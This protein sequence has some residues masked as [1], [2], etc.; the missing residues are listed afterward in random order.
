MVRTCEHSQP[1]GTA[2]E[3][4]ELAQHK[5]EPGHIALALAEGT[6]AGAAAKRGERCRNHASGAAHVRGSRA[7]GTPERAAAARRK[8]ARGEQGSA[9][10]SQV[11]T[12][13][14]TY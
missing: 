4:R 7:R 2:S 12:Q 14:T 3:S 11:V 10:T 5:A 1:P 13:T 6:V 9:P 8:S